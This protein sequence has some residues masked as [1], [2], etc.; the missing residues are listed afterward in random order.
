MRRDAHVANFR[1]GSNLLPH[2][3]TADMAEIRLHD[4]DCFVRGK[5]K[6]LPW[7]KQALT[8][9]QRD[10]D[11]GG[12]QSHCLAV[13]RLDWLF[14]KERP[15]RRYRIDVGYGGADRAAPAVEVEHDVDFITNGEAD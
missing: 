5:L 4:A 11:F 6:E 12:D 7:R 10:L 8:C 9:C 2:R 3:E 14:H 13:A 15:H 1:N